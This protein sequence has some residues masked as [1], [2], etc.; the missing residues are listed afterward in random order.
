MSNANVV[1]AIAKLLERFESGD[2]S[3]TALDDQMED[4]VSALE[5]LRG[6]HLRVVRDI[7]GRL[8]H[9]S[10]A[11]KEYPGEDPQQVMEEL[12]AWLS[13]VPR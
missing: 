9:A 4:Y 10:F 5:G 11:D 7:T 13:S 6:E 1:T 8:V 3:A 12:K 2:L